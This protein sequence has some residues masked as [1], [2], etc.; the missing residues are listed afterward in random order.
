MVKRKGTQAT[1]GNNNGKTK[2]QKAPENKESKVNIIL[3]KKIRVKCLN[4]K[5]KDY[6]NLI[7]EKEITIDKDYVSDK[8]SDILEDINLSKYIL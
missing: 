2:I 6:L 5:Q 1:R 7:K 3:G 4:T 8:L